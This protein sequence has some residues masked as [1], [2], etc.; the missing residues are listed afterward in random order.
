MGGKR[1]G[2]LCRRSKSTR[3]CNFHGYQLVVVIVAIKFSFLRHMDIGSR[4]IG[5]QPFMNTMTTKDGGLMHHVLIQ[6]TQEYVTPH[7]TTTQIPHRNIMT[8]VC[9]L[10][11]EL[12]DYFNDKLPAIDSFY[13]L[14]LYKC[15]FKCHL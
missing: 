3:P 2:I 5:M 8:V 7:D 1:E 11:P 14:M 13:S 12:I 15:F 10:Q 9:A 4:I 6:V